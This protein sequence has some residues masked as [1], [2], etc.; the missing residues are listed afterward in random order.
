MAHFRFYHPMEVRYGD[1]DPQ[2]HV[3]IEICLF[4][5]SIDSNKFPGHRACFSN[6]F[7]YLSSLFS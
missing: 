1:L 7:I 3:N 5:S 6:C 4:L 2:G